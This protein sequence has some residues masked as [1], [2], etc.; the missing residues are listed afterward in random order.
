MIA[1]IGLLFVA[2]WL[3]SWILDAQK[4]PRLATFVRVCALLSAAFMIIEQCPDALNFVARVLTSIPIL[5]FMVFVLAIVCAIYLVVTPY[6]E[7]IGL[8]AWQKKNAPK[9]VCFV[10]TKIMWVCAMIALSLL[11]WLAIGLIAAPFAMLSISPT[12]TMQSV[13]KIIEARVASA[14]FLFLALPLQLIIAAWVR[15]T[16]KVWPSCMTT[17]LRRTTQ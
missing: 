7:L 13:E 15:P 2:R 17:R 12:V 16:W 9:T 14:F 11:V 3:I 10:C 5:G 6:V 4:A 1:S 8:F